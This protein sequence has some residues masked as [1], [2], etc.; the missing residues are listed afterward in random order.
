MTRPLRPGRLIAARFRVLEMVRGGG[1]SIGYKGEDT[2]APPAEPWARYVFIKQRLDIAPD[3]GEAQPLLEMYGVL[4]HALSG[5]GH[6]CLPL[7]VDQDD[8]SYSIIAVY[9]Y[10]KGQM[11]ADVLL[12]NPPFVQKLR[13]AYGIV[14]ACKALHSRDVA[15][16]DLKP[17]NVMVTAN[18][19]GRLYVKV[20]DFEASCVSGRPLSTGSFGT[21]PY[22]AP[23]QYPGSRLGGPSFKSDMFALG[24]MLLS[25]FSG[26]DVLYD[27]DHKGDG[28]PYRMERFFVMDALAPPAIMELLLRCL[29]A[30]PKQRPEIEDA[31]D[32]ITESYTLYIKHPTAGCPERWHPLR[33]YVSITGNSDRKFVRTYYESVVLGRTELSGSVLKRMPAQVCD[34]AIWMKWA[35]LT[36]LTNRV[37][38]KLDGIPMVTGQLYRLHKNHVL[39]IGSEKFDLKALWWR[40]G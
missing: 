15:H 36:R 13:I 3:D 32:V 35:G 18:K 5:S 28:S 2:K 26:Q 8:E 9:P 17:Q 30:D 39:Q 40:V 38:V 23:E 14:N 11:L 34:L 27:V 19:R 21:P 7:Y 12:S 1:Q 29:A 10:I 25:I 4:A 37:S 16:L 20:I 22:K 24:V 33:Q 31:V 6:V